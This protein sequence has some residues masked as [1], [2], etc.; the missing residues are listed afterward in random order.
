[1]TIQEQILIAL[2]RINDPTCDDCLAIEAHLHGRHIAQ[3]ICH[4]LADEGL[5]QRQRGFCTLCER[6]KIA[7]WRLIDPILDNRPSWVRA[8]ASK[9]WFSEENIR[10]TIVAWLPNHGYAI[11]H[12]TTAAIHEVGNDII[13]IGP[14]GQELWVSFKG[15]ADDQ[16]FIQARHLFAS[17]I[18]DLV[19]D[20]NERS[21]GRLALG[22]PDGFK[23]Y[24]NLA[25]RTAW[26]RSAMPFT[27]F[28][29]AESGEV[30]VE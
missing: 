14:D 8:E 18:L 3:T 20:H 19:L 2:H 21:R 27:I 22:L 4:D 23:I 10:A 17:A 26:L 6:R 30:R 24:R 15:Y 12:V 7:N 16:R 25:A 28:W 11:S 1:M 13:A 5:I 9:K 29:V